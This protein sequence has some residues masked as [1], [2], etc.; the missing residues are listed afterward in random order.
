MGADFKKFKKT[1]TDLQSRKSKLVV[2]KIELQSV[3]MI[4]YTDASFA[5][6]PGGS[7]QLG[8]VVFIADAKGNSTPIAWASK[9]ARRVARSTL[10]AETLAAVEGVD[11]GFAVKTVLEE[12]L[13]R[14]L[15]PI[16]LYTDNK[17]L[18]DTARTSNAL[19]DR[20]LLIDMSALREM[21]DR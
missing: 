2:R 10:T 11:A 4:V 19:A 6:L 14:K 18:Y 12:I 7:S 15:P 20:R 1:I 21:L 8:Y 17:S 3:Q 13:V 9:K 5:N 16:I